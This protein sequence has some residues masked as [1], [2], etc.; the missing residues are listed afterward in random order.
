MLKFL[1]KTKLYVFALPLLL[2]TLGAGLNQIAINA[3]H[4]SMPVLY[5]A[6]NVKDFIKEGYPK[7]SQGEI[8]TD[9]THSV[10]TPDS[11]FYV[12][13]DVI[14]FGSVKYSVGDVFIFA[15]QDLGEFIPYVWGLALYAALRKKEDEKR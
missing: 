5:N 6:G 14:D 15:S 2:W 11:R 9:S 12:L 3:N 7:E 8:L 1:R 10:L 13:C 4:D